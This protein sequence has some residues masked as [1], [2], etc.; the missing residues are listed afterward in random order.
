MRKKN[1]ICFL[2]LTVCV[3]SSLWALPQKQKNI[4]L[5]E[6]IVYLGEAGADVMLRRPRAFLQ[7]LALVINQRKP[8]IE[9]AIMKSL[10]VIGTY[11]PDLI[12]DFL[13][14]HNVEPELRNEVRRTQY[15]ERLGYL[16]GRGIAG[17][18]VES[19]LLSTDR[20]LLDQLIWL[21]QR[22][23]ECKNL[24]EWVVVSLK[25]VINII[26]GGDVFAVQL[27]RTVSLCF[28]R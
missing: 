16:I 13:E 19:V 26:Y 14:E 27:E 10:A 12:E 25:K 2:I 20:Y 17:F 6:C 7:A 8:E 24:G 23:V 28:F 11:Y 18:S 9:P 4:T 3:F 15:R 1:L 5:E 21:L 22:A